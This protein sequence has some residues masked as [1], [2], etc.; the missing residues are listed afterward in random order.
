MPRN[1]AGTVH[2]R[3]DESGVFE[4]IGVAENKWTEW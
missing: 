1:D 2:G 3:Q 4:W